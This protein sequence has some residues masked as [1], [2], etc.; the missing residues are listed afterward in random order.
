MNTHLT[1]AASAKK[2]VSDKSKEFGKK[3]RKYRE[4]AR[5]SLAEIA[6][7]ACMQARDLVAVEEGR[8]ELPEGKDGLLLQ[9]FPQIGNIKV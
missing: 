6:E 4:E 7:V 8:L 9:W 3:M 1:S 5:I 2:D